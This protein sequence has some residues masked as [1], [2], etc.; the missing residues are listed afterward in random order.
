MYAVVGG[1]R[2]RQGL[3][4]IVTGGAGFIG[5]HVVDMLL[6]ENIDVTVLDN[7]STGRLE[8]L[9]HVRDSIELFECD[10]GVE[11]EWISHFTNVD[12]VIHWPLWQI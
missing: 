6:N 4:A 7:L 5:S 1:V 10:L 11:G 2:E 12:W 3:K 8:N 9:D